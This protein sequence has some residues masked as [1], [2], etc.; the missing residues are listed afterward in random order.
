MTLVIGS[1]LI[2]CDDNGVPVKHESYVLFEI[3][4]LSQPDPSVYAP[5]VRLKKLDD[6]KPAEIADNA[7]PSGDE[8]T[9]E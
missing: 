9:P 8:S 3:T 2:K 5:L 1:K 4:E 6:P 7:P